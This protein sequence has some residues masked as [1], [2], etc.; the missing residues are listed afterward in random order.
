M[1]SK[2]GLSGAVVVVTDREAIK[3]ARENPARVVEQGVWL[4]QQTAPQ[5]PQVYTM[6]RSGYAM[7]RLDPIPTAKVKLPQLVDA[8][9]TALWQRVGVVPVDTPQTMLYAGRILREHAPALEAVA[10]ERLAF[11]RPIN[12]CLTHGDPTAENVMLRNGTY[13]VIDPIPATTRVPDDLAVD[14]GKI[15]QSAHGWEGMK[16]EERASFTPSDV[17]ELFSPSAF[18]VATLWCIVHFIRTLPYASE[19]VRAR[20]I[21]KLGE[22]LGV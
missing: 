1:T 22:L 13:V 12:A 11:I 2:T 19:E 6:L 8:L 9:A 15:L 21:R 7:E 3:V 18:E 10:L 17:E 4:A 20:V 16:G 5:L 14:V